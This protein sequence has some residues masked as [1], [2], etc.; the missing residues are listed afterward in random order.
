[1]ASFGNVVYPHYRMVYAVR[2]LIIPYEVPS[3][4]GIA[5]NCVFAHRIDA[6]RCQ[7]RILTSGSQA[8][9]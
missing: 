4:A 3:D 5:R 9:G 8:T 1:M 7:S 2:P 6:V